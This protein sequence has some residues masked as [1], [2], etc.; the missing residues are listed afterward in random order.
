VSDWRDSALCAQV[1]PNLWHAD[2]A[3]AGSAGN[4]AVDTRTAMNLCARCTVRG[5]CFVTSLRNDE[6]WGVWGGVD[7]KTRTRLRTARKAIMQQLDPEILAVLPVAEQLVD[8][9]HDLDQHAVRK[10]ILAAGPDL[11]SL[12]I[13]LAAALNP[14]EDIVGLLGWSTNPAEYQRL[15]DAGVR[16]GAAAVLTETADAA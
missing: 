8:A 3:T 2:A 7:E 15:R 9:V 10:A 14:D 4:A 5:R 16:P 1:D 6:P 11:R 12:C 13:A